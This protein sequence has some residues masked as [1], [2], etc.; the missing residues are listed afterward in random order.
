ME[1][2]VKVDGVMSGEVK[3]QRQEVSGADMKTCKYS[4]VISWNV[5]F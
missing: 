3:V 2:F 5:E 1:P 4:V